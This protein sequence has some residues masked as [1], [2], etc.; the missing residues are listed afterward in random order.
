MKIPKALCN[1]FLTFRYIPYAGP[2]DLALVRLDDYVQFKNRKE[3]R[4]IRS[5]EQRMSSHVKMK[6][7]YA[8]YFS[9]DADLPVRGGRVAV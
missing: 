9:V 2:Y 5:P 4:K 7:M 6:C 1:P 8:A 3:K